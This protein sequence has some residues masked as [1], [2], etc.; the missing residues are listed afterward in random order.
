MA[1][2]L[3]SR[4]VQQKNTLVM[5][6]SSTSLAASFSL[7]GHVVVVGGVDDLGDLVLQRGHQLGVVV[8]QRIDGNAAQRVQVLL[9]VHVP[10]AAALAMRQR[11]RHAAVGV[12]GVGRGGFDESG[13]AVFSRRCGKGPARA[14][15]HPKSDF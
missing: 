11:N 6:D 4:P 15:R 14:G 12:H 9:A 8:A 5:P 7:V 10:H 1:A 3:A 13:H 2:S